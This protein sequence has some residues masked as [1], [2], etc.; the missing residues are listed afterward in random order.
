MGRP[1]RKARAS[2][3]TRDANASVVGNNSVSGADGVVTKQFA[4]TEAGSQDSQQPGPEGMEEQVHD[5]ELPDTASEDERY[6]WKPVYPSRQDPTSTWASAAPPQPQPQSQ[7]HPLPEQQQQLQ[8]Q[9]Q[10]H[11][12]QNPQARAQPRPQTQAPMQWVGHLPCDHLALQMSP[13]LA[14]FVRDPSLFMEQP[15]WSVVQDLS[16]WQGWVHPSCQMSPVLRAHPPCHPTPVVGQAPVEP[17]LPKGPK[18]AACAAV[19]NRRGKTQAEAP[20]S[21][22][23]GEEMHKLLQ[24]WPG[25]DMKPRC[26]YLARGRVLV[27]WL[28]Q[29]DPLLHSRDEHKLSRFFEVELE[30]E[31]YT[32]RLQL[33]AK[34]KGPGRKKSGFEKAGGRGRVQVMMDRRLPENIPAL[35]VRIAAGRGDH[36]GCWE[37]KNGPKEATKEDDRLWFELGGVEWNFRHHEEGD[38]NE[39]CLA[40]LVELFPG[41]SR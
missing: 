36:A 16:G 28:L 14:P 4:Q 20:Q 3:R 2:R 23:T 5:E 41:G 31:V 34:S 21:W 25:V 24:E 38:E 8:Q 10:W 40:I 1:A 35:P 30:G 19:G 37:P 18:G 12:G 39:K 15:C 33:V 27:L 26:V 6:E 9:Q 22:E 13:D 17:R 32:L 11:P 29:S 7:P